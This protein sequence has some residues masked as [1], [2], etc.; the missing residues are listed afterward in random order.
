MLT[1]AGQCQVYADSLLYFSSLPPIILVATVRF[2]FYC[3]YSSNYYCLIF[4][5][6]VGMCFTAVG[7]GCTATV[8]YLVSWKVNVS[9]NEQNKKL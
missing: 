3:H 1:L 9:K 8:G 7:F 6:I 5:T 4:I 2:N